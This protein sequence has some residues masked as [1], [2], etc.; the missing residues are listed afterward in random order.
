MYIMLLL[1]NIKKITVIYV[2]Y[3]A[4]GASTVLGQI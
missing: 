1:W 3:G 4:M 2:L